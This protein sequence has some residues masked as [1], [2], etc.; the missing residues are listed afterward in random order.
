MVTKR[1]KSKIVDI[2]A[3]EA[4]KVTLSVLVKM[5]RNAKATDKQ[6]YGRNKGE[7]VSP[8]FVS[9]ITNE[10][11][12]KRWIKQIL[13]GMGYKGKKL[14]Y[15]SEIVGNVLDEVVKDIKD[16]RR[17]IVGPSGT[18][19]AAHY[20]AK[21]EKNGKDPI[22]MV[23]S[24]DTINARRYGRHLK[25]NKDE[26]AKKVMQETQNAM[27][28][29][30]TTKNKED[31]LAAFKQL[32]KLMGL[33]KKFSKLNAYEIL[34]R[35]IFMKE[36]AKRIGLKVSIKPDGVYDAADQ[37]AAYLLQSATKRGK[38]NL[39][40]KRFYSIEKDGMFGKQSVYMALINMDLNLSLTYDNDIWKPKDLEKYIAEN[41]RNPLSE[42]P[43]VPEEEL[44][45]I[46]SR[47]K[48]L[49]S[50]PKKK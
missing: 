15:F 25:V 29:F 31:K 21:Y 27:K 26:K 10:D 5:H 33:D 18:I 4:R 47:N 36:Y 11:L 48:L 32:Q 30:L 14:E 19:N 49:K 24:G 12:K 9:V 35:E 3:R 16:Y 43:Y 28:K 6:L 46:T 8:T 50:K 17:L 40:K 13:V 41:I 20:L 37:H 42:I 7:G 23:L 22:A 44:R 38:G 39:L 1:S 34:A 2:T 45:K